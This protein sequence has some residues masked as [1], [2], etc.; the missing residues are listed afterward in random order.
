MKISSWNNVEQ[1]LNQIWKFV[2]LHVYIEVNK[3]K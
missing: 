1:K 3:Y 2:L